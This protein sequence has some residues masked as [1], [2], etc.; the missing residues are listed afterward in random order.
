M[1][2]SKTHRTLNSLLKK[3]YTVE[4]WNENNYCIILSFFHLNSVYNGLVYIHKNDGSCRV[5]FQ[6]H[7]KNKTIEKQLKTLCK[8]GYTFYSLHHLEDFKMLL[9]LYRTEAQKIYNKKYSIKAVI[10]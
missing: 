3:H 9:N 7:N 2:F 10:K 1:L 4:F 8:H 6:Y 5:D